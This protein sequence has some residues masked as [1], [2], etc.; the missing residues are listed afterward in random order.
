MPSDSEEWVAAES[1]IYETYIYHCI[2][3]YELV[4]ILVAHTFHSFYLTLYRLAVPTKILVQ[5]LEVQKLEVDV[6]AADRIGI[7]QDL[8]VLEY[9]TYCRWHSGL[10]PVREE[11]EELLHCQGSDA[12]LGKISVYATH[13]ERG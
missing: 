3:L 9:R 12:F 10:K 5:D 6:I 4:L 11:T 13:S 7:F 1:S 2:G 8:S